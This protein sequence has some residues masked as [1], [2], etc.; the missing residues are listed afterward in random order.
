MM[1]M[2]G[3]VVSVTSDNPTPTL[4]CQNSRGSQLLLR[5]GYALVQTEED[6]APVGTQQDGNY[7][8]GLVIMHFELTLTLHSGTVTQREKVVCHVEHYINYQHQERY[9][10]ITIDE[11]EENQ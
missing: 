1:G 9:R 5:A 11:S 6:P 10:V 4:A 7:Y 8:W 2:M 3:I